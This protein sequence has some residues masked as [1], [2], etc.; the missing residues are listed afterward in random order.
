MQDY[1][2]WGFATLKNKSGMHTKLTIGRGE[3]TGRKITTVR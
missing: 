3:K 2:K 1:N